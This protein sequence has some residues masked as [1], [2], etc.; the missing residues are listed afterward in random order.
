MD[1]CSRDTDFAALLLK[2]EDIC[3]VAVPSYGGR[4]PGLAVSRLRQIKGNSAR[5][6]LIAVY[7]NRAYEDTLVELR[8]V[9]EEAGFSCVAAVAAVAEHSI[10]RQFAAGRP[11]G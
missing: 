11:D 7:G 4:V 9:L 1:L 5:A 8:D 3:L 2:E 6:V 10:M